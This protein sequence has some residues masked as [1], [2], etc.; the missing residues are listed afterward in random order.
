VPYTGAFMAV[1]EWDIR[2]CAGYLLVG[3]LAKFSA[4]VLLCWLSYDN[5]REELAPWVALG[6][7]AVV[8]VLSITVSLVYKRRVHAKGG[9]LRSQ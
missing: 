3:A 2:K 7:V 9:A 5:I 4:V 8:L 6:A 1:C